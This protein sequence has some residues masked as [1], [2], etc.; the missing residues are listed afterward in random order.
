M[1]LGE[2]M[3]RQMVVGRAGA[4]AR[5]NDVIL[6]LILICYQLQDLYSVIL[7]YFNEMHIMN[8]IIDYIYIY[9]DH[10]SISLT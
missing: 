2:V 10:L 5:V 8:S 1:F 9:R 3:I 6:P 7:I 4:V